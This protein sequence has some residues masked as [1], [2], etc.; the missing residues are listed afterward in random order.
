ME[1]LLLYYLDIW[2]GC[3]VDLQT[4]TAIALLWLFTSGHIAYRLREMMRRKEHWPRFRA[5][6]I[7]QEIVLN[8]VNGLFIHTSTISAS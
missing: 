7:Y 2:N 1:I 5:P 4:L 6:L 8:V 3:T